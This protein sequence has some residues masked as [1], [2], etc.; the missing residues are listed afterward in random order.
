MEKD[1]LANPN[2]PKSFYESEEAQQIMQRRSD[3]VL[4]HY[5]G[6]DGPSM[7]KAAW[8]FLAKCEKHVIKMN[9]KPETGEYEPVKP[10]KKST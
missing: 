10:Y 5:I 9:R 8:D 3:L 6:D 4:E 2:Q 1:S 7:V